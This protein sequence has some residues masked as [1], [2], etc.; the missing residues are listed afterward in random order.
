VIRLRPSK[1]ISRKRPRGKTVIIPVGV[2]QQDGK[3]L[4][5]APRCSMPPPWSK[6][7]PVILLTTAG[8]PMDPGRLP[9]ILQHG[10]HRR[11][12]YRSTFHDLRGTVV[13]R[14]VL[15]GAEVPEIT[16][17]PAKA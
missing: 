14:L 5:A 2:L 17:L 13:T 3:P 10:P 7:S 1:T 16:P 8:T 6:K 12:Y 11:R 9:R 4:K 15:M